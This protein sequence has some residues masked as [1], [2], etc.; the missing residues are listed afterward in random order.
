MKKVVFFSRDLRIGGMEKALVSL[1]NSLV[2]MDLYEVTLVLE[3]KEGSLLEKLDSG[4]K[5]EEYR[6]SESSN[7]FVRKLYNFSKRLWWKKKNGNKYDFACNYA[8]YSTLGS[9]LAI[10]SSKNSSLYVHSDY[11]E[12]FGG[13]TEEIRNF[14]ILQ[15]IKKFKRIKAILKMDL[16][17]QQGI[18]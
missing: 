2:S 13:N 18:K 6:A 9:I 7:V 8:T 10:M 15:G 1:L 3:K 4:V 16:K 5:V 11:F 14:F 17:M 12:Y